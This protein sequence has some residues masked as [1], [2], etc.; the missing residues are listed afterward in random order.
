MKTFICLLA[1]VA[2][3]TARKKWKAANAGLRCKYDAGEWSDC[4]SLTNTVTRVLWL[5]SGEEGCQ[6]TQNQTMSCENYERIQ[7]WKNKHIDRLE[8]LEDGFLQREERRQ[9]KENRKLMKEQRKKEKL[10]WKERK[11]QMKEKRKLMKEQRLRCKYDKGDWSDCDNTTN[12]VTREFTLRD[13]EEGCEPT[14]NVSISCEMFENVQAWKSKKA[15]LKQEK[16][17]NKLQRKEEKNQRREDKRKIK[18]QRQL[19]CSYDVSFS[20]CDSS[21]HMV[22]KTYTPTSQEEDSSCETRTMTYSCQLYE[23]LM[24]KR[25]ERKDKRKRMRQEYRQER[26]KDR[27]RGRS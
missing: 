26:R 5:E 3:A 22:T 27:I 20:E 18:E 17:A 1:L 12:T 8:R 10:Q 21:T 14:F 16:M 13:F 7:T 15:E 2:V 6:E 24:E 23:Q 9:M 25:N 19:G 4:D 11:E